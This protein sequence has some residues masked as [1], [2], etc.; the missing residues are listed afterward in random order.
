MASTVKEGIV[1]GLAGAIAV[2]LWFLVY[3]AA[4]GAPFRTPALLGAALFDGLRDADALVVT[5]AAVVKYTIAHGLAF[6]AFGVAVSTLFA[7]I[8]RERTMLFALFM[9]FCCF[10]VVV[11]LALRVLAYQ[12]AEAIPTW[13]I[14]GANLLATVVMLG[15]LFRRHHQAPSELLSVG[16]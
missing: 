3:D 12:V 16:E 8:D 5:P 2:A 4:I 6:V 13:A 10:E 11:V 15:L 7:M 9:L 14:L 1:V